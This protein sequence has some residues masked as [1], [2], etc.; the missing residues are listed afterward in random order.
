MSPIAYRTQLV[1]DPQAEG[2]EGE[3]LIQ[4]LEGIAQGIPDYARLVD[5]LMA[6]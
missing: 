6:Y 2:A 4:N 1:A 3:E 5:V